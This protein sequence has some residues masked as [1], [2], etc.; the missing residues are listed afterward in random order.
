M[1]RHGMA[2]IGI[3]DNLYDMAKIQLSYG[4]VITQLWLNYDKAEIETWLNYVVVELY[5]S[6][7]SIMAK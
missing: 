5:M 2:Q 4:S 6:C 7:V 1:A 3:I